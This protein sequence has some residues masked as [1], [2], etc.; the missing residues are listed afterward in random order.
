MSDSNTP[1]AHP[2]IRPEPP[3]DCAGECWCGYPLVNTIEGPTCSVYGSHR[4]RAPELR[5]VLN[6]YG[7]EVAA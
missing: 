6:A 2:Q 7:A 1:P 5:P 3:D 4:L